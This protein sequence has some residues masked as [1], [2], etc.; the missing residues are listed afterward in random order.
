M[1]RMDAF[2]PPTLPA[3]F[4]RTARG[5]HRKLR[6]GEGAVYPETRKRRVKGKDGAPDTFR[7]VTSYR[8]EV[9]ID[10]QRIR[11]TARSNKEPLAKIDQIRD[12]A[13]ARL[14][15]GKN[16]TVGVMLDRYLAGLEK[17]EDI[18]DVP[19]SGGE[20]ILGLM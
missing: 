18:D 2:S 7:D 16:P 19:P 1:T 4:R 5:R 17:S 13:K 20:A 6:Y 8:G 14:E 15:L 11:V 9:T 3:L 10:S 12:L